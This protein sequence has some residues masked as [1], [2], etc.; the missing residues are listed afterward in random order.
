MSDDLNRR[1][2][3]L[4]RDII[5]SEQRLAETREGRMITA[6][7]RGAAPA[8]ANFVHRTVARALSRVKMQFEELR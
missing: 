3:I 1:I 6:A 2:K 4:Q 5:G 8:V 7:A